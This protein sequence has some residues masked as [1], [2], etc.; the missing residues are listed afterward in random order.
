MRLPSLLFAAAL[1]HPAIAAASR[2]VYYAGVLTPL[3]VVPRLLFGILFLVAPAFGQ[4]SSQPAAFE[5]AS[6]KPVEGLRGRMYDFSASGPRVRY[7]AYETVQ[8]VMEAYNVKNYQVTFA[9]TTAP[10]GGEHGTAYYDIEAKAEGDR[11]RTRDEF[12]AMLQTLL[13]DRFKLRVHR[14]MKEIPVYAL[15]VGKG[16]TKFKESAV[17]ATESARIGVNGRNQSI[18]ASKKSMDELAKMIPRVFSVGRPVVDRTGLAGAYDFKIE[19]TPESRMTGDDPDL[20][21]ISIFTAVQQQLGLKL[22]SQK[23]MIEVLVV[24]QVEKPSAN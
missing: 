24:D 22:E 5:V 23:A 4:S 9:P 8:L 13:A 17:D 7:I 2:D 19:A 21:A 1:C 3:N 14:D 6:V 20:N 15:L 16:G 18:T 10:S 11:A 12:R